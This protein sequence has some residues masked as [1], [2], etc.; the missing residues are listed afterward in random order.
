MKVLIQEK[1]EESWSEISLEECLYKTEKSGF[2]PPG[3]V[4]KMLENGITLDTPWSI[5]K[6]A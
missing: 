6:K 1:G 2:Y 3:T 5:F 4:E